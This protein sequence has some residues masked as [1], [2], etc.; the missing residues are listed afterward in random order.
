[1]DLMSGLAIGIGLCLALWVPYFII[2][3]KRGKARGHTWLVGRS[4]AV[5]P[6][7][8]RILVESRRRLRGKTRLGTPITD[9]RLRTSC[10]GEAG[11]KLRC[12]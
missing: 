1:M 3:S 8:A 11:S 2:N 9:S 4:R 10:S 5:I 6:T 12:A 7:S